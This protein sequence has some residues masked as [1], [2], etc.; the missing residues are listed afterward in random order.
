[1][2]AGTKAK[3]GEARQ[4]VVDRDEVG[5]AASKAAAGE[6]LAEALSDLEPWRQMGYVITQSEA[7][8]KIRELQLDRANW[9]VGTGYDQLVGPAPGES[10]VDDFS[11]VAGFL[12]VQVQADAAGG[13]LEKL[14]ERQ[15]LRPELADEVA[16]REIA[17]DPAGSSVVVVVDHMHVVGGPAHVELHEIDAELDRA[18]IPLG[19][20]K[21]LDAA[22]TAVGADERHT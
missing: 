8:A 6:K 21:S 15:R 11:L 17:N 13:D 16:M 22:R 4:L 2:L 3:D 19:R 5:T 20:R 14:V 1:V 18:A 7:G 12:E 10:Q 9:R